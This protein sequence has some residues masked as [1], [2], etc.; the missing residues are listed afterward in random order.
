MKE[1]PGDP[2][3]DPDLVRWGVREQHARHYT[4]DS[5][6][7]VQVCSIE[8]WG[9][10]SVP[11]ARMARANFAYPGWQITREGS[12]L[13]M[14]RGLTRTPGERSRRGV[15]AACQELGERVRE[16]ARRLVHE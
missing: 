9:F 6:G 12:L 8:V 3:Q 2:K 13:L 16:R 11:A 10:E 7:V 15:F 5:S 14:I 1:A 4:R